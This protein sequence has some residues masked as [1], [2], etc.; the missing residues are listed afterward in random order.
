M[1]MFGI[2][3]KDTVKNKVHGIFLV[4]QIRRFEGEAKGISFN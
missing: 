2:F 4:Q 3:S 1:K